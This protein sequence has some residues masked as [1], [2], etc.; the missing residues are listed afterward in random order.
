MRMKS[1]EEV[2]KEVVRK[3]NLFRTATLILFK[4]TNNGKVL[5][6][7]TYHEKTF[8]V[9]AAI[10][11]LLVTLI[12]HIFIAKKRYGMTKD[13]DCEVDDE[14]F[15]ILNVLDM[16]R[17]TQYATRKEM[18][19][20]RILNIDED[21][22]NAI[23]YVNDQDDGDDVAGSGD[24]GPEDVEALIKVDDSDDDDDYNVAEV[25]DALAFLSK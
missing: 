11:Q 6:I 3:L 7:I 23:R 8:H 2:R 15:D 5:E 12:E 9:I 24:D 13:E 20:D 4:L 18:M 1:G 22:Y 19:E 16:M 17:P 21:T 25:D 10:T 14:C